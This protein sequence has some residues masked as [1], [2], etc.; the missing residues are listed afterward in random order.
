MQP[1]APITLAI[2]ISPTPFLH[3]WRGNIPFVALQDAHGPEPWWFTDMT[4]GF[5]TLFLAIEPT[6]EG[7][8]NA[9][10][11][12]WVVAVRHDHWT[13]GKTWMHGGSSE[14]L[15]F[16]R[17]R[18]RGWRW[19]D[20]PEIQ[21]PLVSIVV[22]RPED[23]FEV[24]RPHAGV[25]LRVRCAWENTQQGLLRQPI[26]EFVKLSLDGK[27]APPTLVSKKRPS[28]PLLNDHYHELQL[29]EL[30]PGSHTA[31]VMVRVIAT[32]EERSRTLNF[33]G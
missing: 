32:G 4:T 27:E 5:R 29:R 16:V 12:N 10:K 15:E 23:E 8:L 21:R 11:N 13:G 2:L 18:E 7:W 24:A 22:V 33:S 17:S 1:S 3:R 28:G 6:W 30:K 25:T 9:L 20:N 26:T 19:W 14:V 31:T